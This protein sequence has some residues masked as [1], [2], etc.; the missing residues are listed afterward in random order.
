VLRGGLQFAG[1][2][3]NP[4]RQFDTDWNNF[5]PR[6]GVVY[7]ADP[8]TVVRAGMGLFYGS[9]SIGAGGF[10][11]ASQGFAP[12]TTFVG[13]L[14]GLRPITV[15]SN[16]FP[17]GFAQA[18]GSSEGL[19]SNVGQSIARIYD[20]SAVLPYNVQ[21]S[22]SVQRQ[23]GGFAGQASYSANK[24]N[25]LSDGAGFNINQLPPAVLAQGTALQQLVPNPFAGIVTNPGAV[26]AAQV[27]RGQLL[28]PY[29]Q[30]DQLTIFN[31]A[32]SSSIYHAGT[33]KVERRFARGLGLLASYTFSK[34]ISDSPATVGPSVGHQDFYNRRADRSVVE[35]DIPHRIVAS[36]NYTLPILPRN[37]FLGGW[38]LNAIWQ[39][40]SGLPIAVTASPN[41]SNS[42]GGGQRPNATGAD[43]N[44]PGNVQSKLNAYLNPAAFSAAAPFTFGNVAR[45]LANVRGP[46]LRNLDLS[47]FKAFKLSEELTLQFRAESFNF[48]NS[49]MFASPNASFG[50]VAFGTI[51][52]TSN[53]PR[54]IQFALRLSF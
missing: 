22:L 16:P 26:R 44:R 30:F 23:L 7:Q 50:S 32:A 4:R 45:T 46:H 25:H 48:T 49:P 1:V 5:A 6:F 27:T 52:S 12:S 39:T 54:Q 33:L 24:G 10:N 17:D 40:Q 9:G 28:R 19:L 21:W 51:T 43:A 14:D 3:G 11:I 15:L 13:S 53:N 42:L 41:T 20:R 37:R 47:L 34:N 38:Q 31:P 8:K 18:M 35:E 2:N 29:P 36:G